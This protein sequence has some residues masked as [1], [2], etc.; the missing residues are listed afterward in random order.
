MDYKI[1]SIKLSYHLRHDAEF[2]DKHGWATVESVINKI[3]E[4]Y[5]EFSLDDLEVIVKTD[6]KSRYHLTSDKKYI[7]ANQGHSVPVELGLEKTEPPIL[8]YHGTGEQNV[9]S[10]LS[11]GIEKRKRNYVHLS[12]DI[13]TAINVGKRKGNPA[14]LQVMAMQMYLDG[15][16]FY[17]SENGIYLIDYVPPGY[18]KQLDMSDMGQ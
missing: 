4:I 16:D 17:I 8:V 1:I 14:V 9:D 6:E 5:P 11:T 15:Y 18:I 2:I 13:D 12:K 3:K 7:R 10:I